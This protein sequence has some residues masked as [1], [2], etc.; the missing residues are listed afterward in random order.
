M[1]DPHPLHGTVCSLIHWRVRSSICCSSLLLLLAWSSEAWR[2]WKGRPRIASKS[3]RTI[4]DLQNGQLQESWPEASS[5]SIHLA[6]QDL[7]LR[8]RQA[9]KVTTTSAGGSDARSTSHTMDTVLL[10]DPISGCSH[11]LH[12]LDYS[13]CSLQT[14]IWH[15]WLNSQLL[16]RSFS[17]RIPSISVMFAFS[18]RARQATLFYRDV[19]R[20]LI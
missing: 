12:Q 11:G 6:I 9:D 15:Q 18:R 2:G 10:T 13:L 17:L 19:R 20:R 3:S 8:W 1:S 7:Q 16:I 4:V 5:R 14:S